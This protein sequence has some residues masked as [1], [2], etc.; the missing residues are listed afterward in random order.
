MQLLVKPK[1]P[2][3]IKVAMDD[4]TLALRIEKRGRSAS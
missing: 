4:A 2:E 3:L 1:S